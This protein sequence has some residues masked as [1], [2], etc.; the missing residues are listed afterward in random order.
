MYQPYTYLI[1]WSEH[2]IWYYGCEYGS[3][4]K[5]AHPNNLWTSYFTSSEI[6]AVK[7][8][9]LGEPDVIKVDHICVTTE[10]A[11]RLEISFLTSVNAAANAHWLNEHNGGSS[12]F[13]C[14]G[15]H[16][17][18]RKKMSLSHMGKSK[19]DTHRKNISEGLKG[20]TKWL[21]KTH[22]EATKQ[23]M[24]EAAKKRGRS[25]EHCAS[26]SR[27]NKG[28]TLSDATKAK[29]S[30]ARTGM[31]RS[32]ETKAKISAASRAYRERL[33]NGTI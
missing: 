15:H 14:S 24:S 1:G 29:M 18:T 7:R 19:S 21:G 31:K 5:T 8:R 33:R 30:S 23:K 27:A 10:E 4:T 3:L 16:Q 9:V 11:R 2:D 28:K 20:N 26:L 22:S 17:E 13:V 6:V 32:E 12:G 25:A